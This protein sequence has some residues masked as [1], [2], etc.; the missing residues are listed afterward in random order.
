MK[1]LEFKKV[2]TKTE[3]GKG[4][5]DGYDTAVQYTTIDIAELLEKKAEGALGPARVMLTNVAQELKSHHH[6]GPVRFRMT[7]EEFFARWGKECDEWQSIAHESVPGVTSAY[8]VTQ[9]Q[10]RRMRA[11]G[12]APMNLRLI[13][14]PHTMSDGSVIDMPVLGEE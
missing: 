9:E 1:T 12:E 13:V 14:I 2:D 5:A 8:D 3:Y 6:E 11:R 10:R 7:R 4:Y